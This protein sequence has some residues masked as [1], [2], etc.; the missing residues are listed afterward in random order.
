[1]RPLGLSIP[2]GAEVLGVS[3][4]TLE[5][6]DQRQERHQPG[7]GDPAG[8]GPWRQPRLSGFGMQ[9][10]YDLTQAEKNAA[11]L[12]VTAVRP[13]FPDPASILANLP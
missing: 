3:R 7:N 2:K 10:E 8:Q 12:N 6:P 5:Q 1:M 4:L 11:R 13:A 9:M